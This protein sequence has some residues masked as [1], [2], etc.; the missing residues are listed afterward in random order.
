MT[1]LVVYPSFIFFIIRLALELI[2]W[3]LLGGFAELS[4]MAVGISISFE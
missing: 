3:I 4:S 1:K 2:G